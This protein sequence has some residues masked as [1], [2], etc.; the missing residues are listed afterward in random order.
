[1]K[2]IAVVVVAIA[3]LIGGGLLGYRYYDRQCLSAGVKSSLKVVMNPAATEAD[4]RSYM[5]AVRLQV[6]TQKDVTVV[7]QLES[8]LKLARDAQ[9]QND[10]DQGETIETAIAL[11]NQVRSELGLPP[12][13]F[14]F[15]GK[16]R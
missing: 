12:E 3:T 1:M 5:K 9:S 7:S 13:E 2:K 10:E 8:A 11:S 4:V 14:V 15:L 6:R 16:A